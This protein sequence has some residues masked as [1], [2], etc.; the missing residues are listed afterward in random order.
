MSVPFER[1][2]EAVKVVDYSDYRQIPQLYARNLILVNI[3]CWLRW[4]QLTTPR[5]KKCLLILKWLYSQSKWLTTVT[6]GKFYNSMQGNSSEW[7]FC[8]DYGDCS[9]L[10]PKKNMS[11]EIV[12]GMKAVKVVDYSDY[13]QIPQLYARKLIWVNILCWL[14]WLQL[15]TPRKKYVCWI[16]NGYEGRQSG[17]LQWLQANFTTLCKETHLNEYFVLTTATAVDYAPK[18]ICLLKL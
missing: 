13:R 2:M 1:G 18:K 4:L 12:M 6:T 16:C 3:L 9:W 11:V 10:R 5:K 17:W 15:T 7:I 8:V 14:R